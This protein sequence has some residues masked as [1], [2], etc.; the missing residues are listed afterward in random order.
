MRLAVEAGKLAGALA[1][2]NK[3]A[4]ALAHLIATDGALAIATSDA[5][6]AIKTM[7]PANIISP[8][9][10]AVSADQLG[11]LVNAFAADATI[12]MSASNAALTIVNGNG[13]YCLPI[14]DP[15]AMLAI[16]GK[17]NEMS[18]AT[19]D[20]MTLFEPLPAAESETT[21]FYLAGVYLHTLADRFYAVATNGVTL[22][23]TS[24][25]ANAAFPG[26]ITPIAAV[27]TLARMIKQTKPERVILRRGG[28]LLE[29]ATPAFACVMRTIDAQYPDYERILPPPST[30]AA[31]CL[32]S[33]LSAALE[34]MA[35]V[36]ATMPIV[37]LTWLAGRPLNLYL[38]RQ[39]DAGSDI[40]AADTSGKAQIA[41]ALPAF[42]ALVAEFDTE[43]LRLEA[44]DERALVIRA[45]AK[46][47][48]LISCK[49]N[50]REAEALTAA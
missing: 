8:G 15:P 7:V 27:T 9:E 34:R 42:A 22:L 46:L 21:R 20:L 26:V 19:A 45:D 5:A 43:R 48:V 25:P 41:L 30:N 10:I 37:A 32:R 4:Q 18:L 33:D 2:R 39:P 38:A 3:K 23:R 35:T 44:A 24:V 40:I 47:G 17:A 14:T 36:A 28:T 16:T 31:T 13:R 12:A 11:K 50:F 6:A 1:M 29:A 49:W